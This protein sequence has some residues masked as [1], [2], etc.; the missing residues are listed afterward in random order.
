MGR[1]EHIVSC[2]FQEIPENGADTSHLNTLHQGSVINGSAVCSEKWFNNLINKLNYHH[3][4]AEYDLSEDEINRKFNNDEL[5][6]LDR[7]NGS[8]DGGSNGR[9]DKN[10]VRESSING[11]Q[12]NQEPRSPKQSP[13]TC[14]IFLKKKTIFF[15]FNV[16]EMNLNVKQIGPTIVH[17]KFRANLFG[18][19][20]VDAV[21][22]Q[23][24]QPLE[25]FKHKITHHFHTNETFFQRILSK[26]FLYGEATMVS[27]LIR[28]YLIIFHLIIFHLI[29][30]YL[31]IFYL[32]KFYLIRFQN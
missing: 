30:F 19:H 26:L 1:T 18:F 28:F 4:Y 2:H 3:W 20:A 5:N 32:F 13:H 29:R 21:F 16:F 9:L 22:I 14:R 7:P 27:H 17:L 6:K 12:I 31:I 11:Q 8:D 24:I 25:P 10:T 15:S 23:S